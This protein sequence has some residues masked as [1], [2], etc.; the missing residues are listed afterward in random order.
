MNYKDEYR[1]KLMSADEAMSVVSS[2]DVVE[3]GHFSSKPVLCDIA[4]AKRADELRDV[5][6]FSSGNVLP[7]PEVSKHPDAFTLTDWHWSKVTRSIKSPGHPFS[8]PMMFQRLGWYLTELG[9]AYRSLYY[10]DEAKSKNIKSIAV[11]QTCPMDEHGHFNFGPSAT[12]LSAFVEACDVIIIEV[13]KN[14]PR[15]IGIENSVHISQVHG[16]IE[17]PDGQKL[18]ESLTVPPTDV[19]RKIA[20]FLMPYIHDGCC[21]QLGIGGMPNLIGEMIV[22]SDLKDLGG[23]TEMFVESFMKM[24]IAGKMTGRKKAIDRNLCA[25]TFGLGSREMYDFMDLN[26][27]LIACPASYTNNH[28]TI[29]QLDNFVSINNALH[30]DLFSQVSAESLVAN[31]ITQQ[32]SGNGGMLDF[33]L[34]SHESKNGKSFIAISSTFTDK[35]G[36]TSSRIVPV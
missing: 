5:S 23:H 25:Y 28:K 24:I 14:R 19:E 36:Q 32:I 2:G 22:E 31:G 12:I 34:G 16:I 29:A 11:F 15:C 7:V 33:V 6:V 20:N 10:N 3:Y 13:N 21:L 9:T 17:V 26:Q 4:L 8:G 18:P 35:N 30:V 27:A 1:K